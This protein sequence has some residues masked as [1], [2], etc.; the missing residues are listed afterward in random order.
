MA[1]S[2]EQAETEQKLMQAAST[3][4]GSKP[5]NG[6]V[7][8]DMIESA[9]SYEARANLVRAFVR[10]DPERAALVVRQM[11]GQPSNG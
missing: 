11:L 1:A 4:Q 5:A 10:Q 8:I 6:K 7:T 3:Q 9:P 2:K